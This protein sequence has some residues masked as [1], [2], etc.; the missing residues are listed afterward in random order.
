[1]LHFADIEGVCWLLLECDKDLR[2]ECKVTLEKK[3]E[4]AI[5]SV[6]L[7][8]DRIAVLDANRE[9]TV[10]NYD[11]NNTKKWPIMRK[12][13]TKIDNIFTAPLGKILVQADDCLFM[14]DMSARKVT[15]ELSISEVK[16]VQWTPQF[17]HAV[18]ITKNQVLV[19]DKQL[20]VLNSLKEASKIKS[21]CF[22]EQNAFVYSTS[23]HIKYMFLDG[24]TTGTFKSIDDPLYVSFFMKDQIYGIDRNG[25]MQII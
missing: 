19:V 16:R 17:S 4:A 2:K 12:G 9:V 21:G 7:S 8:K 23:T 15:C 22:D 14:Y 10:G 3:G 1:L 25:E 20:Q 5:A 13:M 11:G 18:L 24:Q 6:F